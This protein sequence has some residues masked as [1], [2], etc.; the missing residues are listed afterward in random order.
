MITGEWREMTDAETRDLEANIAAYAATEG[1]AF[2]QHRFEPWQSEPVVSKD[3]EFCYVVRVSG[4]GGLS[5]P[6]LS[7]HLTAKDEP[8]SFPDR[9]YVSDPKY[10]PEI[11]RGLYGFKNG[12]G[13]WSIPLLLLGYTKVFQLLI[14]R[15]SELDWGVG[16]REVYFPRAW[17]KFSSNDIAAFYSYLLNSRCAVLQSIGREMY[18]SIMF[19][20]GMLD[21]D[22][23]K[24]KPVASASYRMFDQRLLGDLESG[25]VAGLDL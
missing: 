16:G 9:G 8:F 6:G 17:V 15:E 2:P 25:R 24:G 12:V 14:V 7:S 21:S 23:F 5:T 13:N 1:A 19:M 18:S 11:K 10:C 20:T 3:G 4:A 22:L